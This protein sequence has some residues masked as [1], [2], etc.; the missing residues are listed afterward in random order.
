M[1]RYEYVVFTNAVEG[2]DEEFNRWYDDQHLADVL[3][4]P[5]FL[6]AWRGRV[7]DPESES[8]YRYCAVYSIESDDINATVK[9]MKKMAASGQIPISETLGTYKTYMVEVTTPLRT[10]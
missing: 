8:G 3:A 1:K 2:T 9:A 7:T 5:G 6:A 10:A 4:V